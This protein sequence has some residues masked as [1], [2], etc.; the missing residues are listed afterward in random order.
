ME[1]TT[2]NVKNTMSKGASMA[3]MATTNAANKVK[4]K[5]SSMF[6]FGPFGNIIISLSLIF[7]LYKVFNSIFYGSFD[8]TDQLEFIIRS[9]YY[10]TII[11]VIMIIYISFTNM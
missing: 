11:L 2:K 4:N 5:V 10:W 8:Y 3:A 7:I 9:Y 1:N 6:D